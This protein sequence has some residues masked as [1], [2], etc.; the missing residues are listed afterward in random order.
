ME[1]QRLSD[2]ED[3]CIPFWDTLVGC[4]CEEV[5]EDTLRDGVTRF[6][7]AGVAVGTGDCSTGVFI[8][9]VTSSGILLIL[10][11]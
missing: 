2:V 9:G 10:L 8:L 3:F 1:D 11:S 4:A 7:S 6:C 5:E